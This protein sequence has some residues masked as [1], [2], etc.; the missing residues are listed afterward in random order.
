MNSPLTLRELHEID[1]LEAVAALFEEIW[2]SP[3]GGSPVNPELMRA[4]SHSGNYVA[5]AYEDGRLV[6]ASVGFFAAPAGDVLH[7]HVTGALPGRAAGLALKLHQRDWALARGLTR[8]T[9][10]YDPLIRR[11]AYFNLTKLGARPVEYLPRFYGEMADAINDGDES[12][13]ALISW[14]LT[15]YPAPE[16]TAPADAVTALAVRDGRPVVGPDLTARTLLIEVPADIEGLRRTDPGAAK[17]WRLALREV[18]GTLLAEGARV[19]GLHNRTSY[20]VE[21]ATPLP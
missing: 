4:F 21:R 6:G 2:G 9:W 3:P 5:G 7:S 1:D 17:E 19:T 15:A 16:A 10:T 13:R 20:V 11:N 8:I 12:D 18:L 14:D